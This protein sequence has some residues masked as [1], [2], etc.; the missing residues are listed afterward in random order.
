MYTQLYRESQIY[1]YIHAEFKIM[2]HILY[3]YVCTHVCLQAELT[4][5][6]Y[7]YT[8]LYVH[9][10][11]YYTCRIYKQQYMVLCVNTY[12]RGLKHT[13]MLDSMQCYTCKASKLIHSS[14]TT[15]RV[16][17]SNA[18]WKIDILC[19]LFFPVGTTYDEVSFIN[20][21]Q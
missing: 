2:T 3:A 18:Q 9:I 4:N 21:A 7:M 17:D 10:C 20:W 1:T 11:I 13:S 14:C 8:Y 6:P 19:I 16:C 5:V 15:P 12:R